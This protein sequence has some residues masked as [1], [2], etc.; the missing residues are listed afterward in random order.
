[1]QSFQQFLNEAHPAFNDH[2]RSF[3]PN[4]VKR[5][6]HKPNTHG[7][8]QKTKSNIPVGVYAATYKEDGCLIL[9]IDFTVNEHYSK[10]NDLSLKDAQE[11]MAL[12]KKAV[13]FYLNKF[14]YCDIILLIC[15]NSQRFN[16]FYNFAALMKRALNGKRVFRVHEKSD[17]RML[18]YVP[19]TSKGDDSLLRQYKEYL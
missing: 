3:V 14:R 2:P 5:W 18:F 7:V 17:N 15:E 13:F 19:L 8:I 6:L 4:F 16:T 12:V 11:I 10:I 1:M 9:Q